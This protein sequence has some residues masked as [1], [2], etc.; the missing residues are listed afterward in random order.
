MQDRFNEKEQLLQK[1]SEEKM[2]EIRDELEGK[3]KELTEQSETLEK[4]KR[5]TT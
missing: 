1:Q 4:L 5:Q 2:I 3:K